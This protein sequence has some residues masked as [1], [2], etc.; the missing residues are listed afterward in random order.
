MLN[1]QTFL[2]SQLQTLLGGQTI[3]FNPWAPAN[4]VITTN[5]NYFFLHQLQQQQQASPEAFSP[6]VEPK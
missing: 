1:L 5:P 2:Q 4:P 3:P 6:K